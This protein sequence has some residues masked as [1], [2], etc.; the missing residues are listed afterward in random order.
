MRKQHGMKCDF[1]KKEKNVKNLAKKKI[2]N[3]L[4]KILF[5]QN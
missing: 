2:R 3:F 1:Q 5:D 4:F